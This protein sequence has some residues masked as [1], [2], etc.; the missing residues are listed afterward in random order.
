MLYSCTLKGP[1]CKGVAEMRLLPI[2][3]A[4]PVLTHHHGMLDPSLAEARRLPSGLKAT[5]DTLYSCPSSGG[6]SVWFARAF[7]QT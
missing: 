5:L 2:V 4:S 3:L 6:S 7:A 1:V